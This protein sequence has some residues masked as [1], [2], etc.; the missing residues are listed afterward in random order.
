MRTS[1]LPARLPALDLLRSVAILLVFMFHLPGKHGFALFGSF[2]KAGWV[3]VD[4]FFVLSGYLIASQLFARLERGVGFSL[5]EFYVRRFLRTFPNFFVVLAL[6]FLIP[7]L[8]EADRIQPWWMFATFTLNFDLLPSTFSHAWSLCVEEHFYLLFPLAFLALSS[9]AN[10]PARTAVAMIISI[11]AFGCVFGVIA[12]WLSWNELQHFTGEEAYHHFNRI[13]YYPTWNRLDGLLTGVVIA[14]VKI[15]RPAWWTALSSKAN[16]TVSAG[17]VGLIACI[18]VF[19]S[20]TSFAASVFGFPILSLAFGLIL[21]SALSPKSL[22]AKFKIP[23]AET[24]AILSFALYLTHKAV[25]HVVQTLFSIADDQTV[26]LV[27]TALPL[28]LATAALLYVLVERPFLRLR[29]Y[30]S[31]S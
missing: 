4:L 29:A 3:G 13:V 22:L 10:R 14:A 6:Y 11:F 17:A 27:L 1:S 30:A 8:R 15:Y 12:R 5:R 19:K 25:V 28:C 31:R 9:R 21:I 16:L 23:G 18:Y 7:Y 26:T 24:L 2:G 20:R